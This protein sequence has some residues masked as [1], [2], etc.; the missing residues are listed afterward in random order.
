MDDPEEI[1]TEL[2]VQSAENGLL[3]C[4]YGDVVYNFK[5]DFDFVYREM[6]LDASGK[7]GR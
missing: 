7:I 6:E 3:M 2:L 5:L 4:S 1:S